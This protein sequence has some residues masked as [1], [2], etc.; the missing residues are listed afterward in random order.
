MIAKTQTKTKAGNS[1]DTASNEKHTR[2]FQDLS[3]RDVVRPWMTIAYLP[4]LLHKVLDRITI[5]DILLLTQ[6]AK[7]RRS[8]RGAVRKA[9]TYEDAEHRTPDDRVRDRARR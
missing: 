7:E 9:P 5:P 3:P 1:D 2:L 8:L 4:D 6:M